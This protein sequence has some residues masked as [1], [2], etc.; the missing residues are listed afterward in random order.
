MKSLLS[1]EDAVSAEPADREPDGA[2]ALVVEAPYAHATTFPPGD[3]A[4]DETFGGCVRV[5][6]RPWRGC[7]DGDEGV[8]GLVDGTPLTVVFGAPTESF[9]QGVAKLEPLL[10]SVQFD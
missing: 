5:F 7:F 6:S 2:R 8:V 3:V 1:R 4:L 9:D 10:A